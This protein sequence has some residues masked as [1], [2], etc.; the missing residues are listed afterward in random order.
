VDRLDYVE[1]KDKSALGE[2]VGDGARFLMRSLTWRDEIMIRAKVGGGLERLELD[3]SLVPDCLFRDIFTKC[4]DNK[5]ENGGNDYKWGEIIS[6]L[7]PYRAAFNTK[8]GGVGFTW[9]PTFTLAGVG[10]D[11]T[12]EKYFDHVSIRFPLEWQGYF[13]DEQGRSNDLLGG[14]IANFE[15]GN[16][17]IP[18]IGFGPVYSRSSAVNGPD[19]KLGMR[20]QL[21]LI[22]P[23]FLFLSWTSRD[24]DWENKTFND[25]Y[26]MVGVENF[27]ALLYWAGTIFRSGEVP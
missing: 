15:V 27:N 9:E 18:R 11:T 23:G 25:N 7:A 4:I 5:P 24:M 13:S 21:S 16:I 12:L 22:E 1:R 2:E 8:R 17:F 19:N 10:A 26:L 14:A 20:I 3:P 6:H